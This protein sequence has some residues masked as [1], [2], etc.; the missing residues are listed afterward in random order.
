VEIKTKENRMLLYTRSET[1]YEILLRDIK[2]ANLAYHTYPL[3]QTQQPRLVVKGL[4]PNIDTAE[5]KEDLQEN[6]LNVA[7]VRQLIR[8][9]KTTQQILQKF[10]IYVVT[11]QAATELREVY[12]INKVCHC[13]VSLERYKPKRPIA[14][15]FNCQQFGY[16]SPYCGRPSKCVKCGQQHLTQ[17]C[18]KQ[19]TDLPNCA[20]CGG[21][22]PANYNG[23]PEYQKRLA[24]KSRKSLTI[25]RQQNTPPS[26]TTRAP[27]PATPRPKDMTSQTRTWAHTAAQ[28]V[29]PPPDHSIPTLLE[30]LKAILAN[31]NLQA[32]KITLTNLAS[33][34]SKTNDPMDK[35]MILVDTCMVYLT[36]P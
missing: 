30:S 31:F 32:L 20:N 4:P 8:T 16:A 14:Q 3:S 5:I 23:C 6:K 36:S 22:H 1:D 25:P 27:L 9:D 35:M 21:A 11:L 15:C 24:V 19:K 33:K 26:T 28:P 13:I 7:Q 2:Q 18:T 34:L 12:K 17:E 10:P 29:R